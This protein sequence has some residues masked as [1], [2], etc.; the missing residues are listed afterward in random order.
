MCIMGVT[1]AFILSLNT[2]DLTDTNTFKHATY[3]PITPVKV[4]QA[5]L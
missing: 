2:R 1:D 4:E 3:Q 5:A